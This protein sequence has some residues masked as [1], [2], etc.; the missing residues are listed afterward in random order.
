MKPTLHAYTRIILVLLF[1]ITTTTFFGQA[2]QK[3][4]YQAVIRDASN[5]LVT[6]TAV[7]MQ[8]SILQ[9]TSTG[10]SVYVEKQVPTTNTNG[11]VS[12][13]IGTGAVV[14]G[15]FA[16]INWA[17]G[18]YF[19]K[20]ETDPTGGTSYTITGTSQLSSVPYALYA[21]SG[22]PGPAGVIAPGSAVGN[23]TYWDGSQWVTN[24][25]FV[26]NNGAAVGINNSTPDASAILDV[27]S[28]NKGLLP[29]RMTTAQRNA[30][31]SPAQGLIIF[32]TATKC[33]EVWSGASWISMCE[34]ACIPAPSVASAGMDVNSPTLNYTLQGNNPTVGVGTWTIQSGVGGSLS[35]TSN[36]NAVLTGVF[37]NSYTLQWTISNSCGSSSDLVVINFGC[38]P[39]Y[40]NCNG[41][42]IDGCEVNTNTSAS[43]C[44]ACGNVCV[45][46]NAVAG[47]S[48]GNCVIVSCNTGYSNCDGNNANGCEINTNTSVTNCGACGNVCAFPNAVAG[49]SAGGCII[50]SC[51]AGYADCDG[52]VANGCEVN[53]QA[54]NS[55]CGSCGLVCPP[56]TSCI[57][58]TCQ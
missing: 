32:N 52:N 7:G 54:S 30:I 10:S 11:L 29:P 6:S 41:M 49:C 47:C 57:G 37:G 55:N 4:S 15:N 2:P 1:C 43:N 9:G 50:V 31:A 48:G 58:G 5:V 27:T 46:P 26:Y 53:L 17:A 33:F 45:F 19:I 23:T 8:I 22:T 3:M 56:G 14:S 13:E 34:G 18:P 44:G 21:A 39:G 24:S 16:T 12:L 25:N 40:L 42:S 38:P 51:N 28:T 20:T 36:P 35:S